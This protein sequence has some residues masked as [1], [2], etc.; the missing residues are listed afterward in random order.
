MQTVIVRVYLGLFK[1]ILSSRFF[2]NQ[3]LVTISPSLW[4]LVIS[5]IIVAELF[6]YWKGILT[7][8]F[9]SGFLGLQ[10]VHASPIDG[11]GYL[12]DQQNNMY[13]SLL[14]M[15]LDIARLSW[16]DSLGLTDQASLADINSFVGNNTEGW[17]WAT[18]LEFSTIHNWFDT[19]PLADGWSEAQKSG[20]ALFF[21]LNGTGP[22]HTDQ[23]GY[24]FEGYTY[25]QFGTL[26]DNAMQYVW[27]A[28]FA[29][30]IPEVN[31]ATYSELCTSGYFTD[32]N[33]PLW[34]AENILEMG[35][36]NVAPLLVRDRSFSASA[37][38]VPVSSTFFLMALGLATFMRR[39]KD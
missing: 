13:W 38:A 11:D 7:G 17:R 39:R 1:Y 6:M 15:K 36:L 18:A 3:T 37:V 5:L 25:W 33:S 26:F 8:L 16:S 4:F 22:A 20:T 2:S 29:W 19:D 27:M 10:H 30:Q 24:D 9:L 12:N 35:N 28:D 23:N 21:L 34:S 32:S 31:C 14:D